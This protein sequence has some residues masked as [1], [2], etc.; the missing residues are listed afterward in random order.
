M[1][2]DPLFQRWC[3]FR[4][5]PPKNMGKKL[6]N[7]VWARPVASKL[8]ERRPLTLH[9]KWAK[10]V[11]FRIF[12][13]Y[14]NAKFSG[15]IRGCHTQLFKNSLC[16]GLSIIILILFKTQIL[17]GS[18]GNVE[19]LEKNK[20]LMIVLRGRNVCVCVKRTKMWQ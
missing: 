18:W 19:F 16:G 11:L 15:D 8:S 7:E 2:W 3:Q 14:S 17:P 1:A 9:G 20:S 10:T 12:A 13:N 5:V 6:P 4:Y